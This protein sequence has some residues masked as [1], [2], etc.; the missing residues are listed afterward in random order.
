MT[1]RRIAAFTLIAALAA[2]SG[3]L[4]GQKL[5]RTAGAEL[6]TVTRL[7]GTRALPAVTLDL[8]DRKFLLADLGG[9]WTVLFF[10][11]THCPDLCPAT[12]AL[13]ARA[14]ATLPEAQRPRVLLISVD[15]E[16]DA[17]PKVAA[18]ARWFAPEFLGATSTE[19]PALA[20]A[21]GAPYARSTTSDGYTMDHSGALFLLDQSGRFAAVA[22]PPL[23][24]DKLAADLAVL[25]AAP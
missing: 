14:V 1:P 11:F 5:A 17:Q 4:F 24:S 2:G 7:P 12:L 16:R 18:F 15:P 25:V 6:Q 3:Y 9:R 20:A 21:L 23:D 13:L 22:T 10:G 8:G 19:L